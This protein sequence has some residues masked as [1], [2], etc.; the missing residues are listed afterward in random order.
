[1]TIKTTV[2]RS[3]PKEQ[4]NRHKTLIHPR[5]FKSVE[6]FF[7]FVHKYILPIYSIVII[8]LVIELPEDKQQGLFGKLL[9]IHVP[10]AWMSMAAYIMVC[11]LSIIYLIKRIE[12]FPIIAISI[13]KTGALF[14]FF[15]LLTGCIWGF[16]VWG[17]FWVWDARLISELVLFFLYIGYLLLASSQEPMLNKIASYFAL[18]G[19][20]N[21]PIIK[22]SVDWWTT[23]HQGA[24][25][26]Q[27]NAS[28]GTQA[29]SV[30]LFIFVWCLLYTIF[31]SVKYANIIIYKREVEY[32]HDIR[33]RMK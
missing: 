12:I 21:L 28:I 4:Q 2:N 5:L 16:H 29:L 11:I 3:I 30:M 22:Y 20:I 8:F 9:V 26:T 19:M 6:S 27:F 14:T 23:M 31:T 1:M 17:T 25:L 18:I 13:A 7:D 15:T 24:S 32:L 10:C 33:I